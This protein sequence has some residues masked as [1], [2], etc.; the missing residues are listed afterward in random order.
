[1]PRAGAP[2]RIGDEQVERVVRAAL[3]ETRGL[4]RIGARVSLAARLGLSRQAVH[5]VWRAFGLQPHRQ[6][7]F[8]FRRILTLSTRFVTWWGSLGT[9]PRMLWCLV[10][11][12]RAKSRPSSAASPSCQCVRVA[13]SVGA[14]TTIGT[15]PLRSL[16]LWMWQPVG[17]LEPLNRVIEA[18][19][20]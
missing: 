19:I 14:M 18:R 10:W 17:S 3:E 15:V 6:E 20:F 1:M 8:T 11:T 7:V 13:P 16:P 5:G 2:R 9:H 4:P 12:K